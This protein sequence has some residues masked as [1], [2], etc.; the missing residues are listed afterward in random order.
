MFIC[1]FFIF[2]ELGPKMMVVAPCGGNYN[3]WLEPDF[4]GQGFPPDSDD[5]VT[6]VTMNSI[7]IK[8]LTA[9]FLQLF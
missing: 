5:F 8:P 2:V 9:K 1:S 3:L 7:V 6:R 4:E